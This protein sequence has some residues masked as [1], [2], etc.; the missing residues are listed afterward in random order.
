MRNS[1]LTQTVLRNSDFRKRTVAI[2]KTL[3]LQTSQTIRAKPRYLVI[4]KDRALMH[5]PLNKSL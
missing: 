4:T 1:K 5:N 3:S 2:L